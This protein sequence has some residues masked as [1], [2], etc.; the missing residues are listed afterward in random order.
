MGFGRKKT[1]FKMGRKK[2]QLKKKARNKAKIT[3]KD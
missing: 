1:A 3:K 2:A